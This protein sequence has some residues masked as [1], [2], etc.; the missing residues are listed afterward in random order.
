MSREPPA[1]ALPWERY[2]EYL[3]LLARLRLPPALRGKL[4]ASDL[5]QQTLLEAHQARDGLLGRGEAEQAAF[6][7]RILT[8]NLTDAARRYA[9]EARDVARE[10]SLDAALEE[11]SSRLEAWL[12]ADDSSPSGRAVRQEQLLRLAAALAE[13][14]EDQR[15]AVEMKH[16]Q[17]QSVAAIG[18]ALGRSE[19]AVGGLLCRGVRRLR[20]LLDDS[21]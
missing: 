3:H 13:L 16:L 2:R 21:S 15:R 12:A 8:N 7:R 9:A 1:D 6:L 4:D 20:Q 19:T 11:S 10:R 14:P 5:V 17:G 18:Q